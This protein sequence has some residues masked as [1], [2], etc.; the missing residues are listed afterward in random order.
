ML[1]L[2][3]A[4]GQ[5]ELDCK[6][7]RTGRFVTEPTGNSGTVLIRTDTSQDEIVATRGLQLRY[8]LVWTRPC[9]YA[10]FDGRLLQ[11]DSAFLG[12]PTD[13]LFVQI[14]RVDA[15]GYSFRSTVNFSD[16]E[17]HGRAKF[18]NQAP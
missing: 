11:G 8:K 2:T 16:E 5:A 18:I 9:S 10:L 1:L 6:S 4:C 14:N 7:V 17:R 12:K 15:T 13:T 3:A